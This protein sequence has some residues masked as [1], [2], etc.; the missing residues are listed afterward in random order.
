[1]PGG[2]VAKLRRAGAEPFAVSVPVRIKQKG[3]GKALDHL[4]GIGVSAFV[5]NIFAADEGALES[6]TAFLASRL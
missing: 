6:I 3:L 5:A 2:F 1:L 4:A